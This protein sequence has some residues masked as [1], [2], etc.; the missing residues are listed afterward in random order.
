MRIEW[1]APAALDDALALRAARA[2]EATVV[3]GG[4][5]LAIL[6]NR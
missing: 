2:D 1:L 5:F 6:M 3:A 4:T